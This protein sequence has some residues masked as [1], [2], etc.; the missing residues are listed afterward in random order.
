MSHGGVGLVP[1]V[2]HLHVV[3]QI[4]PKHGQEVCFLTQDGGGSRG[5]SHTAVSQLGHMGGVTPSALND[6]RHSGVK[7]LE[8]S[9]SQSSVQLE[10]VN[11]NLNLPRERIGL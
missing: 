1:L 11:I 10:G 4:C 9:D 5:S 2:S 6:R 3:P 8:A 7:D